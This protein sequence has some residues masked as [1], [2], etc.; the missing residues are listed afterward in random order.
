MLAGFLSGMIGSMGL[1]GGGVLLIYLTVFAHVE[2]LNAQGINLLFFLPVGLSAVIIYSFKRLIE[3][4]TV[5]K[6][7]LGGVLG[8]GGGFLLAHAIE[9]NLL[10]KMFAAF[11]I[12]FGGWQLITNNKSA[13]N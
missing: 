4:K 8:A 3:W 6:I 13:K 5:L 10:S 9:T 12:V 2:Q 1:G 7:W 11:L